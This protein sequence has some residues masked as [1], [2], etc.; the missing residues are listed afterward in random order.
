MYKPHA[1]PPPRASTRGFTIR[2]GE[3]ASCTSQLSAVP[4][5]R[6]LKGDSETQHLELQ[7]GSTR[8]RDFTMKAAMGHLTK[9][10]LQIVSLP[11]G[12]DKVASMAE[13]LLMKA[14]HIR[15]CAEAHVRLRF[16][17]SLASLR[18]IRKAEIGDKFE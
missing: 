14:Q 17:S 3:F 7:Y 18:E 13:L 12:R 10:M 11:P 1:S 9:A 16:F 4:P 6:Q 8:L 2:H 5:C 15:L